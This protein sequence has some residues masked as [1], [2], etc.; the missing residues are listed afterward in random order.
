MPVAAVT[1]TGLE[2]IG[3][4]IPVE[5]IF[6]RFQNILIILQLPYFFVKFAQGR[7]QSNKNCIYVTNLLN[8]YNKMP[9]LRFLPPVWNIYIYIY[10][11]IYIGDGISESV[12]MIFNF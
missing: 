4:G 10:I 6:F 12:Q 8:Y 3:D 9:V 7:Y 1:T 11:Y 2:Y 5:L